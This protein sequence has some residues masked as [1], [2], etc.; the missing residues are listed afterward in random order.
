[1]AQRTQTFLID[2]LDGSEAEG[3]VLFGLDGTQYEIDLSTS[4]AKELRAALAPFADAGRKVAARQR[5]GQNA[6]RAP[7]SG[8]SNTD[9]RAWARSQG[10]EVKERGRVPAEV[11]ARY[12][13]AAG[14]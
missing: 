11:I 9:V 13:A 3:T 10:L 12:Q 6:R 5:A 14:K 1:M 8:V 2:D 7:A 4:H